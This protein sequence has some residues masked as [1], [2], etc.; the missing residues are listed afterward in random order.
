MQRFVLFL[1]ALAVSGNVYADA[2]RLLN[3][4]GDNDSL[5]T[6]PISWWLLDPENDHVP[7]ISTGMAYEFLKGRPSQTVVV[8]V[9]DS[10]IDIDHEDLKEVIWTNNDEI[11]GNGID[12]DNNG[13]IDDVHGWNFLGGKDG[14]NIE[15]DSYELT[16]EY[17]RL[18]VKY[19]EMTEAQQQA[20]AEWAYFNKIQK[21][22]NN[23]V[24]KME[25]QFARFKEF[26]D[27]YQKAERLLK[28]YTELEE[29]NKEDLTSWD[30]PDDKITLARDI[31][32]TAFDNGLDSE[33]MEKGYEYFTTALNYGYNQEFNPR[34]VIGDN[35]DDPYE[36]IYGNNDVK[37]AFAFHGTHVAGIIAA[38]RMNGIGVDGVANN[39]R[40]MVV[41]AVPNGDERDKDVANAIIYA[42]DNG[43]QII[44]M[45]FGKR[46]S[47]DKEVVDKAVRYAESKGVLLI[48]AAG[49][50]AHDTQE[51]MQYP[52]KTMASTGTNVNNWLEVGA[53]SWKGQEELVATFSNF[54]KTTVDIFAPGVDI[55]STAPDQDYQTASGTS[56]AAPVTTGVAALL[57]SYFP[58]LSAEEIKNIILKSAVSYRSQKVNVP[59]K[60]KQEKFGNLSQTGGV[61]NAYRAVK[62]AQKSSPKG[63]KLIRD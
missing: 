35:I 42:V 7:G 53:V 15:F 54:G 9:I 56:M 2:Q 46:F 39:V 17:V 62:L 52:S 4:S 26:Y 27:Q 29:L 63:K 41:R 44:N 60:E 40:I 6:A 22:Y 1:I 11:A 50:S 12:D 13:Y 58:G 19:Q 59:G 34:Y 14:A 8:A 37:G 30:S 16:R 10:G 25:G 28:A 45:S 23:T 5:K 43:A 47:P 57:M 36:K 32:L 24:E 38:N 20:D 55:K 51:I 21:E 49:N 48:H 18:Q 33:Q 31:V 3:Y 61:V